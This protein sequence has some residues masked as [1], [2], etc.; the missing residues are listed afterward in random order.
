MF[1]ANFY[2]QCAWVE[3]EITKDKIDEMRKAMAAYD[4]KKWPEGLFDPK[5][6]FMNA[7]QMIEPTNPTIEISSWRTGPGGEHIAE[8][9][10]TARG[11]FVESLD[12]KHF[13]FDVQPLRISI[14][15]SLPADKID[16]LEDKLS[17]SRLRPEF[18][19]NPEFDIEEE[20]VLFN[21]DK[22]RQPI[23]V[24]EQV[25]LSGNRNQKF[26]ILHVAVI[27]KRIPDY[28]IVNV[29]LPMFFIV[30]MEAG[31]FVIDP[32]DAADRYS[33]TLTL[34]L[35]VVAYKY[36]GGMRK[37]MKM[38]ATSHRP[39][40]CARSLSPPL[41]MC[42]QVRC[43]RLPASPQLLHAVRSV[44]HHLLQLSRGLASSKL[45]FRLY[46]IADYIPFA[47]CHRRV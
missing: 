37:K 12:L 43:E 7:D 13:P 28:Y 18:I 39:F 26:N 21:G 2:V 4:G 30:C 46:L 29:F 44:H 20:M 36:V 27:A 31:A 38:A 22:L 23:L 17:P 10:F 25:T 14:S 15:S 34:A 11:M 41:P 3:P 24:N 16:L 1:Q 42:A 9:K 47:D 45:P 19:A 35:V 8:Y 32:G 33:V 40:R 5:L 6:D